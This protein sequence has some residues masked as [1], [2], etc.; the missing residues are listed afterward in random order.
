MPSGNSIS[1]AIAAVAG[2]ATWA[3]VY[4]ALR[5]VLGAAVDEAQASI[6]KDG[7][8]GAAAFALL[9]VIPLIVPSIPAL[10]VGGLVA[11]WLDQF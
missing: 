1:L 10:G 5:G 4:A 9:G 6:A 3:A 8:G 2:L 11:K 7:I